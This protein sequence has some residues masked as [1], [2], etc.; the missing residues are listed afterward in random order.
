MSSAL[1]TYD[2]TTHL[3][4]RF[5]IKDP[6]FNFR[7]TT[8]YELIERRL[9]KLKKGPVICCL[10]DYDNYGIFIFRLAN[11]RAYSVDCRYMSCE[12][13]K[14][15]DPFIAKKFEINFDS[16]GYIYYLFCNPDH[17]IDEDGSG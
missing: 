10:Q 7:Y 13:V 1:P 2:Y 11:D 4:N 17:D 9:N 8:D 15:N 6:D 12:I 3:I 14:T 5:G 16:E